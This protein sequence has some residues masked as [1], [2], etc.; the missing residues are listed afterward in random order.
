MGSMD[1]KVDSK[2]DGKVDSQDAWGIDYMSAD[3]RKTRF[4]PLLSFFALGYLGIIAT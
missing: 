4:F 3:L 1:S 2:V